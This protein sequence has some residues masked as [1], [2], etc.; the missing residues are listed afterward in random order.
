DE[1]HRNRIAFF[2]ICSGKY[3]Q[4]M[5]IFHE[6]TGKQMQNSKAL[7]FMAGEREQVEEVYDVDII[8]FHNHGSIQ[9]GD[10][11]TQGEKQKY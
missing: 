8:G 11:L 4:G 1:K 7:T 3:E 2:R 10:S 5:N 6:S 9:I